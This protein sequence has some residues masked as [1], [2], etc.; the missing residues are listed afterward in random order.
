M[1]T[2]VYS[3]VRSHITLLRQ[4]QLDH[5]GVQNILDCMIKK[6]ILTRE[7]ES[8]HFTTRKTSQEQL[9]SLRSWIYYWMSDSAFDFFQTGCYARLGLTT[10]YN[11]YILSSIYLSPVCQHRKQFKARLI[12]ESQKLFVSSDQIHNYVPNG[13]MF[14]YTKGISY[15][16]RQAIADRQTYLYNQLN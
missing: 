10:D 5:P 12:T 15:G 6:N 2:V 13:S 7:C 8:I 4:I 11:E 14:C 3:I 9:R 16:L 1:F